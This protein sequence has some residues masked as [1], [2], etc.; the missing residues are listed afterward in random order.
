[1]SR[2]LGL[3]VMQG[4]AIEEATTEYHVMMWVPYKA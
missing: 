4:G 2:F 1:M 3:T